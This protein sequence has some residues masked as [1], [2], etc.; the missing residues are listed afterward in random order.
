VPRENEQKHE[1]VKRF[2]V[3]QGMKEQVA[4]KI[5]QTPASPPPTYQDSFFETKLHL[6]S[7]DSQVSLGEKPNAFVDAVKIKRSDSRESGF[8]TGDSDVA[9]L[10]S[11]PA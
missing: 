6:A 2:M 3:S 1:L 10:H 11:I 5:Q 7:T 4:V 8:C 9:S